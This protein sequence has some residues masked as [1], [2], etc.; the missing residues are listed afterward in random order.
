MAAHRQGYVMP[1]KSRYETN[2]DRKEL[3]YFLDNLGMRHK[4]TNIP[5]VT[6]PQKNFI[7]DCIKKDLNIPKNIPVWVLWFETGSVFSQ[8]RDEAGNM[9][10]NIELGRNKIKLNVAFDQRN[11]RFDGM[12]YDGCE[13]KYH[14]IK[15]LL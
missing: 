3:I 9:V 7:F 8:G 5:L 6:P 14:Q 13:I 11:S 10:F 2:F 1:R 15:D 4:Y 12:Y